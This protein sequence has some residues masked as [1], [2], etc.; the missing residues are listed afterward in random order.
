MGDEVGEVGSSQYTQGLLTRG[1][2]L[3]VLLGE[4]RSLRRIL[5]RVMP[6]CMSEEAEKHKNHQSGKM[7]L[8]VMNLG[9]PRRLGSQLEFH[10]P[11]LRNINWHELK[12]NTVLLFHHEET[13]KKSIRVAGLASG[14][15]GLP[16]P[17]LHP[18][19]PP[20]SPY[21]HVYLPKTQIYNLFPIRHFREGFCGMFSVV[22]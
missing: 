9:Q 16:S 10:Q 14:R 8:A 7:R 11:L 18:C 5:S 13:R 20:L 4:L 12:D 2:R 21:P 19:L 15:A 1:S 6:Y 3:D 17:V 22:C